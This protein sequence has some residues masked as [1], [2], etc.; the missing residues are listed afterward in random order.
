MK[1]ATVT[2]NPAID[3]TVRIDHFRPGAVNRSQKME[4]NPGGKGV[5]VA[6][7]LADYGCQ[8]AVTGFLGRENPELFEKRFAQKGIQDCFIRLPGA[9]RTNIKITDAANQQTT[10]INMPGLVPSEDDYA[11]L[12]RRI[13]EMADGCDWFVLSGTL[14]PGAPETLYADLIRRLKSRGK[15]TILDTS[16]NALKEGVRAGPTIIKPNLVELEQMTGSYLTGDGSVKEAARTLLEEG[17]QTVVVSMG[18]AGALFVNRERT[19]LAVP[20]NVTVKTTVGAGDAMVAGLVA[21][22]QEGLSLEDCARL[23][24]AFSMGAITQVGARLPGRAVLQGYIL[25]VVIK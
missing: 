4:F 2:T 1:I 24:T 7:F 20:P 6:S 23:A 15:K 10:D 18:K 22:M 3:Q 9:T 12:T 14:P 16:Q 11:D 17:I 5:N 19:L 13:E 21:G 8:V 25:Q